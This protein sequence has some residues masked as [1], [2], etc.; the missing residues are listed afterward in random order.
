MSQQIS[1]ILILAFYAAIAGFLVLRSFRRS[2]LSGGAWFL[3]IVDRLYCGLLY[4]WRANRRCPFP[5][6]GPAII[7]ANHRSPVDPILIWMNNHLGPRRHSVRVIGFMMAREYYEI[8]GLRWVCRHMQSIPVDRHG[9]DMKPAHAALERLKQGHLLGV[10]PE[11]KL[12]KGEGLLEG[13][14][15]MAWLALRARVPIYPVYLHNS[16][17]SDTM[18]QPFY[19]PSR[20]RVTYGEPVDLS[21]YYDRP[22]TQKVLIEVTDLLMRRLADLGGVPYAADARSPAGSAQLQSIRPAV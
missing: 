14:S 20:V 6:T 8:P 11:G 15:G 2:R 4:H 9:R 12:N 10:F 7:I 1:A 19:K 5:E 21:H 17:Q 16:P 18:L 3:F 13:D 22:K